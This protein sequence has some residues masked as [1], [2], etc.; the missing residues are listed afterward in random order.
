MTKVLVLAAG[1]GSRL[2]PFT[3]SRPKALV[4]FRGK[5]LLQWQL[6]ALNHRGIKEL[7]IVAGYQGEQFR[8]Y[9]DQIFWNHRWQD[10]NMV[11]SLMCAVDW[12]RSQDD[13]L[14]TYGDIIF[15]PRVLESIERAT[16]DI[17]V[18]IDR[19]WRELWTSRYEDPIF[20][21]ESLKLGTAGEILDVGRPV[22]TLDEVEGQYI[23]MIRLRGRGIT[24]FIEC[25]ENAREG[26]SWL[27]GRSKAG[28]YMT[29]LLRGLIAGGHKV[30]SAPIDGGWLE[31]DTTTDLAHYEEMARKG[32]L[33]KFLQ[34]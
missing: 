13:V 33:A 10:T 18:V 6:D 21:V 8:P 30:Q 16:S 29:D 27:E 23:G 26:D 9:S 2:S 17:A 25:Y 7:A 24:Q 22:A 4:E 20:D 28:A 12:L 11:A 32:S 1:R 14:I 31:F 3:D 5:P 19:K 15:S 34:V